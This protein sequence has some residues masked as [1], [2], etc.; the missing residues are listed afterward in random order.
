VEVIVPSTI[1]EGSHGNDVQL[2]PPLLKN[3]QA[4]KGYQSAHLVPADGVVGFKTWVIHIGAAGAMVA[5]EV[6]V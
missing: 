2:A 6:G 3:E 4:V 5:D 1:R